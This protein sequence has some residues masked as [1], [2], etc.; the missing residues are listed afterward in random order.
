M[1]KRFK[2]IMNFK[3]NL[4]SISFKNKLDLKLINCASN[5]SFKLKL[6]LTK[7]DLA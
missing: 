3:F 4:V 7:L 2:Y 6:A 5:K 1:G